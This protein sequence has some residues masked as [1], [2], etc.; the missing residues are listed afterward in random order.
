ML[1]IAFNLAII[2]SL[3]QVADAY[4][5]RLCVLLSDWTAFYRSMVIRSIWLWTSCLCLSSEA[6]LLVDL[7]KFFGDRGAPATCCAVMDVL[8]FFWTAL[9]FLILERITVY[10]VLTG[11][12]R[13]RGTVKLLL[14]AHTTPEV[15]AAAEQLVA[16]V[17][18]D[19][20]VLDWDQDAKVQR[21]RQARFSLAKQ[22]GA[23]DQEAIAQSLPVC[24]HG[25][26]DDGQSGCA[27]LLYPVLIAAL[28]LL[29]TLTSIRLSLKKLLLLVDDQV[30]K[31]DILQDPPVTPAD[32]TFKFATACGTMLGKEISLTPTLR[33]RNSV[34]RCL[35]LWR[36]V[37]E[38]T[39]KRTKAGIVDLRAV[40]SVIGKLRNG[41]E[42]LPQ[43]KGLLNPLS[44]C[45][46]VSMRGP[47]ERTGQQKSYGL[48]L[49]ADVVKP[50]ERVN[51][52]V[53]D[54]ALQLVRMAVWHLSHDRANGLAFM[55]A[56][57]P[58]LAGRPRAYIFVDSAGPPM[59]NGII[60][61]TDHSCRGGA[62][63][64][65]V[66]NADG[67]TQPRTPWSVMFWP[68]DRLHGQCSTTLEAVNS[69]LALEAVLDNAAQLGIT[70]SHVIVEVSDNQSAVGHLTML[71]CRAAEQF[72]TIVHRSALLQRMHPMPIYS[73][74]TDRTKGTLA[75]WASKAL[76]RRF[77][78]GLFWRGFPPPMEFPLSRRPIPRL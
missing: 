64:V 42:V 14:S 50:I 56:R 67:S 48:R 24:L 76:F 8:L 13:E 47:R 11:Q 36:A 7:V 61:T 23:S 60:D 51:V 10:C 4:P 6:A 32:F 20:A 26:Y 46:R 25:F 37:A 43:W 35:R 68:R 41:L 30:G 17:E 12:R 40:Q 29:V 70:S 34:K 44:A 75:D 9:T 28:F 57:D 33:V 38:L 15:R 31:V 53:S 71:F 55:P 74:W 69:N 2:A 77:Y 45:T 18:L 19:N 63:Y 16:D 62:M 22:R 58:L 21:W 72:E 39:S 78:M 27:F 52:P 73:V 5:M 65:L 54:R 3:A 1:D 49:V 59:H 66:F